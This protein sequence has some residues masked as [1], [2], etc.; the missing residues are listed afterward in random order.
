VTNTVPDIA[1]NADDTAA[2]PAFPMARAKGCPLE[3]AGITV[4]AD[5]GMVMS[6]EAGNR[7]EDTFPGG[8]HHREK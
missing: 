3:V 4:R 8:D 7:D 5:A 6:N 1:D 2:T